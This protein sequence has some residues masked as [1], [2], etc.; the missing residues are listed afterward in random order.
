MQRMLARAAAILFL[1]S[2]LTGGLVS[3]AMRGA[4]PLDAG[5]ILAAHLD[6][7]MGCFL[8]LGVAWTLPMLRY[9]EAG[10]GRLAWAFIVPCYGNWAITALK[11]WLR[12]AGL[13][14]TGE[15]RNDAVF[16]LL[17]GCVVLPFLAAGAGWI[18]GLGGES[19]G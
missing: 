4:L 16:L 5:E 7:L 11:S 10:R 17:A 3:S 6:G 12:V 8:L 13:G 1:L 9:G 14:W 18:A 19:H 15:A 2:L